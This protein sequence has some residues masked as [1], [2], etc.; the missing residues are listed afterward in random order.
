[1]FLIFLFVCFPV[2]APAAGQESALKVDLYTWDLGRVKE[3]QVLERV[4]DLRNESGRVW[5]ITGINTSCSC[6]VSE[7]KD[8]TIFAGKSTK[9]TVKFNSRGYSPGTVK[10]YIY[11]STDDP[12]RPILKFTVKVEVTE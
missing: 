8:K 7:V 2:K 9:V 3:G 10:Q 6:T 11:V 4:F 12:N 1:M 5:N